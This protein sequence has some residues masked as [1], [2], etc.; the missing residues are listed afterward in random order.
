MIYLSERNARLKLN[1]WITCRS[2]NF[3]A[4]NLGVLRNSV[5]LT[6][7]QKDITKE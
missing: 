7:I 2:I 1:P 6:N 5:E 3:I 4:H